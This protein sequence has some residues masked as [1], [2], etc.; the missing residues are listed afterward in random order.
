MNKSISGIY[1]AE[2]VYFQS[3]NPKKLLVEKSRMLWYDTNRIRWQRKTL[4]TKYQHRVNWYIW[5]HIW[6]EKK[7]NSSREE[8]EEVILHYGED[9]NLHFELNRKQMFDHSRSKSVWV[10]KMT[11]ERGKNIEPNMFGRRCFLSH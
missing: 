6:W 2:K 5:K 7:R 11:R 8:I 4:Y 10:D 9:V 1:Y 3:R